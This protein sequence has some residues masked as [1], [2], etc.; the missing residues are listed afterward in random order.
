MQRKG[1]SGPEMTVAFSKNCLLLLKLFLKMKS[2]L[3]I[4]TFLFSAVILFSCEP[5]RDE[6]GDYL[7][8]VIQNPNTD[9]GGTSADRLLKRMTSHAMNDDTGEWEDS[10]ITYNYT[11]KKLVSYTENGGEPTLF[12]YNGSNKISNLSSS[13]QNADFEYSAGTLS[14]ITTTIA[15]FA[16]ITSNFTYTDAKLT[17]TI[18]IQEYSVPIASKV[19]TETTYEYDGENLVKANLRAGFYL[20]NG[21][22]EMN[23]ETQTFSFEYDAMKNPYQLLPKEF[24]LFLSGIA[25]QGAAYLSANNFTKF[26]NSVGGFSDITTYTYIYDEQNYPKE[27]KGEDNEST[28]F[29]YQ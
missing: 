7:F 22:L 6:N 11:N 20:P 10:D 17:K 4:L 12:T 14:K 8:G 19:Y 18:S 23:P 3:H 25:P 21:E 16:T 27:M 2:F 28:K 1:I 29:E 26:T 5:G 24:I 15:G 13:R 9:G